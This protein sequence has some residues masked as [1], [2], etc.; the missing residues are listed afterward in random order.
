MTDQ[1]SSSMKKQLRD[2]ILN[3]RP[4]ATKTVSLFGNSVELKQPTIGELLALQELANNKER[5]VAVMLNHCYVPGTNDKIFEPEDGEALLALPFS[6]DITRVQEAFGDLTDIDLGQ[7]E[8][9]SK[10]TPQATTS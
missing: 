6:E 7:V 5:I 10:P 2:K 1:S 3:T 8:G 9:N 4:N